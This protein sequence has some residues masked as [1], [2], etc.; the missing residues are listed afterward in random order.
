MA[1]RPA[2]DYHKHSLTEQISRIRAAEKNLL[3]KVDI[4]ESEKQL[5]RNAKALAMAINNMVGRNALTEEDIDSIILQ[6]KRD[7]G[8]L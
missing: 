1:K 8:L 3:A 5:T 2:T 4:D 7:S 6:A